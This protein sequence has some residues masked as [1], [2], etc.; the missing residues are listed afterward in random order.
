MALID[1][2]SNTADSKSPK[3]ASKAN[4]ICKKTVVHLN[5]DKN[6]EVN[7]EVKKT[8]EKEDPSFSR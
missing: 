3:I 5:K 7:K 8:K 2:K 6:K 4:E 1:G